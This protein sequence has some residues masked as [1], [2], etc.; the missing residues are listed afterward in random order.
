VTIF[1]KPNQNFKTLRDI[2]AEVKDGAKIKTDP[3]KFRVMTKL[4]IK[5]KTNMIGKSFS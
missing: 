4:R 1:I 3:I 2:R 5:A